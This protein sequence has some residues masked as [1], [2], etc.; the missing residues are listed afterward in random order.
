MIISVTTPAWFCGG[1]R[2][3]TS[4]TI[5]S[6]SGLMSNRSTIALTD[7]FMASD[8]GSCGIAA[9]GAGAAGAAGAATGVGGEAVARE[10]CSVRETPIDPDRLPLPLAVAQ[11]NN[12]LLNTAP[13]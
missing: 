4:E 10:L 7:F 3:L 5:S 1:K 13:H 11:T 8:S 12:T 9:G 2:S 6:S